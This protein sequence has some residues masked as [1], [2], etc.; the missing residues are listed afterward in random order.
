[1]PA[2]KT[3]TGAVWLLLLGAAAAGC[4]KTPAEISKPAPTR[5]HAESAPIAARPM[6]RVVPLTGT[7]QAELRTELSANAAGRVVKTFVE[8]GQRVEVG[9]ALAQLDVKSAAATAAEAAANVSS[10]KTQLDAAQAECARYDALLSRGAITQQEHDKQTAACKQQAA[11]LAVSNAHAV[12]AA[13]AVRDGTIRAPFAG[14]VTERAVSVGDYVQPSSKVVTL[15]VNN[16]LRLQLT[17]PERRIGDV[18]EGALVTFTPS[19]LPGKTFQGKVKYLSGEVRPTTRDL[20]VEAIVPNDDG[21][22]L[23]G[24]FVNVSLH[25]G[26]R[27]LPV[28]PA[29][30]VFDTGAER[31]L[32]VVK[33]GRLELRIVKTGFEADGAVAVEEGVTAGEMVVLKP[34]PAMSDGALVE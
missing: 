17:V 33:E 29:S 2:R 11:A 12:T 26:E 23:P 25:A 30:A 20:V 31:S 22:L 4:K 5:V 21:A 18:K 3:F 24:M 32:Y 13:I 8:R 6:P 7:L 10:Q 19:S 14:I 9:A 16:P 1:M 34:T 15:V 27:T 28:V